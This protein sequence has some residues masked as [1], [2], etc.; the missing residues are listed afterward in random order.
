MGGFRPIRHLTGGAGGCFK[1]RMFEKNAADQV[2]PGD[3]LQLLGTGLVTRMADSSGDT[4]PAQ[5]QVVGVAARVVQN[6]Q[7]RPKT[8]ATSGKNLFSPAGAT[9]W[10]EVYVDPAIVYEAIYHTSA[11]QA[12]IGELVSTSAKANVSAVGQNNTVVGV[13][14]SANADS[15][16]RIVDISPRSLTPSNDKGSAGGLIEV[17]INNHT[18]GSRGGAV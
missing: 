15:P 14:T 13:P 1:T 4:T 7:G 8:F 2:F 18:F 12:Q 6:R 5:R 3:A 9:D 10:I 17:V 16:F 11:G